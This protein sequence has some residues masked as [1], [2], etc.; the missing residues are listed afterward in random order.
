MSV[1]NDDLNGGL[2]I[3]KKSRSE[4]KFSHQD[5]ICCHCGEYGAVRPVYRDNGVRIFVQILFPLEM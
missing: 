4:S 2:L 3:V 5:V 1:E